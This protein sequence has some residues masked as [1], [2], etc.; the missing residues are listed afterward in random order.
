MGKVRVA[1]DGTFFV[2]DTLNGTIRS[3]AGAASSEPGIVRSVVGRFGP[4]QNFELV[5]PLGLALDRAGN[6]YIADHGANAVLMLHAA[7]SRTPGALEI[8]AHVV[9]ASSV[10][11]SPDGSRAY[12]AAPESGAVVTV[13]PP[14]PPCLLGGDPGPMQTP[15]STRRAAP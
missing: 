14:P 9:H 12:I 11:L 3:I 8:L 6:L 10:A 2:A 1:P 5:E 13:V 7:T 4:R 15:L